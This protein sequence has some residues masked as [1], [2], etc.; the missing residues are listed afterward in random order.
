MIEDRAMIRDNGLAVLQIP[1]GLP[2]TGNVRLVVASRPVRRPYR[3]LLRR[4]TRLDPGRSGAEALAT[5]T[6]ADTILAALS[7]DDAPVAPARRAMGDRLRRAL[8]L[9]H[10]LSQRAPCPPR[11]PLSYTFAV[12]LYKVAG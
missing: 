11:R 6:D 2:G 7:D 5:A 4:L 12:P 9:G 3:K 8:R 10:R 1:G